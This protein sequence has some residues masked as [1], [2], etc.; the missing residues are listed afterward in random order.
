MIAAL[1]LVIQLLGQSESQTIV[2]DGDFPNATEV[3]AKLPGTYMLQSAFNV[4]NLVCVVQIFYDRWLRDKTYKKYNLV[5][6]F[7]TGKY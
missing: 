6:V 2:C 3:I 7:T 1:F 5:Y 4:S